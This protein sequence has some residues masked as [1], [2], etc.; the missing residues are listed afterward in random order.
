MGG[1]Q[2]LLVEEKGYRQKRIGLL[3]SFESN[4]NFH[5]Y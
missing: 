3:D 1:P 4:P 5:T 2:I